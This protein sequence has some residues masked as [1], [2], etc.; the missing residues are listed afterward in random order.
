M[1]PIYTMDYLIQQLDTCTQLGVLNSHLTIMVLYRKPILHPCL[2]HPTIKKLGLLQDKVL[3][4]GIAI[5]LYQ[6]LEALLVLK[7]LASKK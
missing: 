6:I 1:T 4:V 5:I 3:N 7:V 2:L